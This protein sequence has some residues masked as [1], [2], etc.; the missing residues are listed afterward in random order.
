MVMA[1]KR[2]KNPNQYKNGGPRLRGMNMRQLAELLDKTQTKK[3]RAKI[4]REMLR[5][6][7]RIVVKLQKQSDALKKY[8][9]EELFQLHMKLKKWKLVMEEITK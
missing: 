2:K 1:V 7:H 5:Q 6:N 9:K 4:C 8:S 3:V